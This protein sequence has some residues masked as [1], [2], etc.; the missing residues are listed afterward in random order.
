MTMKEYFSYISFILNVEIFN[1]NDS[2]HI[3][4]QKL[5]YK[6]MIINHNTH[7]RELKLPLNISDKVYV[8]SFDYL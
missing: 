2:L 1:C 7:L 3:D 8:I 5:N 6:K 4:F